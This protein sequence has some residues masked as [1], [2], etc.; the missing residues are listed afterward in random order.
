[1]VGAFA[2]EIVVPA[3][4]VTPVPDGADLTAAASWWVVYTTAYH[5]LRSVAKVQPGDRVVVLG[6]AGGVGLAAVDVAIALGGRAIAVAS[7]AE[8]RAVCLERGAE[9]A[10][11]PSDGDLRDSIRAVTDGAGAD[12]VLDPV[13]GEL[14]E[15]AL[16]ATRWGGRFVTVGFASGD[17][18][19]IPLNL[20]LLKGVALLGFEIRSFGEHAPTEAARDR[21]ELLALFADGKVRPYVGATFPLDDVV[22]AL[23][24]VADRKAIGKVVLTT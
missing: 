23:R 18:P 13:G 5:S 12:V 4:A 10:L 15:R 7:T 24:Y 1:M 19:R 9:H 6:A 17:I 16:R 2:E 3:G 22:G 8:K 21:E 11:D 20:V 14:S